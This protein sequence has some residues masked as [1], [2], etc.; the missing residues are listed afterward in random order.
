MH[1]AL[2]QLYA[3][4]GN[5]NRETG[6]VAVSGKD[7]KTIL[8]NFGEDVWR[9]ALLILFLDANP[10]IVS[11]SCFEGL[12]EVSDKITV[13]I[14]KKK[15]KAD[16]TLM[17]TVDDFLGR[18]TWSGFICLGE[19]CALIRDTSINMETATEVN[20]L[21]FS[22]NCGTEEI[23]NVFM[24]ALGPVILSCNGRNA[25]G[26]DSKS[27]LQYL[28]VECEYFFGVGVIKENVLGV[29]KKLVE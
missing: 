22:L 28:A 9:K 11:P 2:K 14:Q 1:I 29:R 27:L 5:T 26:G 25:G 16:E 18:L 13:C 6:I 20:F 15:G 12:S 8:E 17:Q 4:I 7:F 19:I 3:A 23:T 10:A 21:P 24:K